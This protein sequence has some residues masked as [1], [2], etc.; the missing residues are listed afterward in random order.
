MQQTAETFT[1]PEKLLDLSRRTN[2][3]L[4][5]EALLEVN[6]IDGTNLDSKLLF[7]STRDYG[8]R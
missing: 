2:T 3:A 4:P 1:S 5:F 6:A 7:E 8:G